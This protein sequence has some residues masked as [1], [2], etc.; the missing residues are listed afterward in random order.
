M[1]SLPVLGTTSK[2]APGSVHISFSESGGPWCSKECSIIEGCYGVKTEKRRPTVQKKMERHR[3]RGMAAVLGQALDEMKMRVKYQG[4]TSIPWVRFNAFGS[5]NPNPSREDVEALESTF[6]WLQDNSVPFHFQMEDSKK[7]KKY[8]KKLEG[9]WIRES[10]QKWNR[11]I[12]CGGPCTW[13]AG[14]SGLSMKARLLEAKD[15]ALARARITGRTVKV[16]AH[17]AGNILR[18]GKHNAFCGTCTMCSD[19]RIDVVFIKRG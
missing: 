16:C 12:R 6:T 1:V 10:I 17:E 4:T 2:F 7:V 9:S 15:A 13:V 18:Y 5:A 19:P 11:W 3:K 14:T 8:R